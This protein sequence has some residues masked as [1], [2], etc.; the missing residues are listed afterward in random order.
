MFAGFFGGFGGK[1]RSLA[2]RRHSL[3]IPS[4]NSKRVLYYSVFSR[5]TE[6]LGCIDIEIYFKELAYTSPEPSG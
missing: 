2:H 3:N 1:D 5:E 4:K 6:P